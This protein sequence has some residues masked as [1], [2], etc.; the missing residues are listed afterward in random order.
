MHATRVHFPT[1]SQLYKPFTMANPPHN[2]IAT[3]PSNL[4]ATTPLI[5]IVTNPPDPMASITPPHH[6]NILSEI[7]PTSLL[8][9][10]DTVVPN[11]KCKKCE[12][13]VVKRFILKDHMWF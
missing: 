6:D 9:L 2:L 8:S 7:P 3:P 12:K 11:F 5:S 10:Q 4:I 1:S 13:S